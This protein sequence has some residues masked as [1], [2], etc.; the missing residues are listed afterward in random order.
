MWKLWDGGMVAVTSGSRRKISEHFSVEI[1]VPGVF[2]LSV[3]AEIIHDA[4]NLS[5]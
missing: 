5:H 4:V 3:S 1:A 2:W